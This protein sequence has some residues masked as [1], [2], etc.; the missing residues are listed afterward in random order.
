[1]RPLAMLLAIL[2]AASAWAGEAPP[3]DPPE[4]RF[5]AGV[6]ALKE[7]RVDEAAAVFEDLARDVDAAA[8][9]YNLGLARYRQ[10]KMGRAVAAW[11]RSLERDP[12][13]EDV[14]HNLVAVTG[15]SPF[16]EGLAGA[17]RRTYLSRR[18]DDLEW[19]T[20]AL[21][22]VAVMG[23]GLRRLGG[24]RGGT[25]VAVLAL[26]LG[27][28]LGLWAYARQVRWLEGQEAVILGS[29]GVEATAGP[30]GP[31]D[32]PR[33]FT[34][35]PGQ[36]VQVHRSSGRYRQVSLSTG[37]AGWVPQESIEEL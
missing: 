19:L 27:M 28:L 16:G 33:V 10:G 2:A 34:A 3:G 14:R 24:R 6:T 25:A 11:R 15:T 4:A 36:V 29:A 13:A 12:S 30:G 20:L 5:S 8:V 26:A 9:Y 31:G 7:D 1:M 22:A 18:V 37:A 17:L 23:L 32:F 21:L 35:H